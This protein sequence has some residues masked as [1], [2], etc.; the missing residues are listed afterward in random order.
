MVREYM[1]DPFSLRRDQKFFVDRDGLTKEQAEKL[2]LSKRVVLA[3]GNDIAAKPSL[4]A[5]VV[6]AANVASRWCGSVEVDVKADFSDALSIPWQVKSFSEALKKAVPSIKRAGP[7][8]ANTSVIVFGD[9]TDIKNALQATFDGWTGAVIAKGRGERLP[10]RH[11]CALAGILAGGLAVSEVFLN[12]AGVTPEA[13]RRD[14][15]ISLWR[16]D[17]PFNHAEAVGPRVEFLP[18]SWWVL[19]LGHLGQAYLWALSFLPYK[20]RNDVNIMLQDHDI[21]EKTNLGTQVL[22]CPSAI[23]SRKTRTVGTFLQWHGFNPCYIERKFDEHTRRNRDEPALA[24]C[25]FDQQGPRQV[26][27]ECGFERV[28][29]CGVGGTYQDFD[30]FRVHSLPSPNHRA[31]ELWTSK[32]LANMDFAKDLAAKRD[33]YREIER[34]AGCGHVE[35]AGKAVAVPFVGAVASSLVMAE[36]LR[37]LHDGERYAAIGMQLS[38]PDEMQIHRIDGGYR[39]KN[40]PNIDYTESAC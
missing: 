22:T 31:S 26:L 1:G 3:L 25:G 11:C 28:V 16:P 6:T 29:E 4:Q 2:L 20:D 17:L 19:G 34:V 23:G 7:V 15:G 36:T 37:M 27:D 39:G 24:L 21:V 13:E 33:V 32:P 38:S 40:Q 8:D 10:E 18:K 9:R 30:A 35:L 14:V 12:F 5:A